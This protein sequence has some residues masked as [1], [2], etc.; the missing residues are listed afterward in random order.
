MAKTFVL[1][2]ESLNSYGFWMKTSGADISQFEKN[3]IMLFNH[4]RTWRGTED[5]VLPIGHWENIRTEGEKILAEPAFDPDEF[6]QK[7][8]A[9]VEAGT[10]RMASVGASVIE[11]SE[12]TEHIKPGQR[13]ATVLKWKVKEASIVDIGA[14]D[15]ALALYD[16]AE[17]LIELSAS[18]SDI[19]LKEIQTQKII[20]MK[21]VAEIL[22]LSEGATEQEF[23]DA[24]TPIVNE[25]VTLKADLQTE[26]DAVTAL[27]AKLD[28]IALKEKAEAEANA[29]V[30]VAA[31]IKDGRLDDD[32]KHTAESFWL[33]NFEADFDSTKGQLEKLPKK[34]NLSDRFT[35]N[36][37]G[38]T[39]WEKRRREI[40]ENN[41]RK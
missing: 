9:K 36:P 1:H 10:L 25:N 18:G 13:Y 34:T 35:G 30:L 32:E 41:K 19:P 11:Q 16:E 17:K 14:N 2:D 23:V 4:N 12:D 24:I 27:Q 29:K 37:K 26:K 5:E 31:A 20:K 7:I 33:R 21:K 6:S 3:P 38:E 28:A 40:D 39:A 8:K 22:K 15:N